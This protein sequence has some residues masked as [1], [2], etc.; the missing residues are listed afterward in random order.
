MAIK[1][2]VIGLDKIGT[3]FGLALKQ[4]ADEIIRLGHDRNSDNHKKALE[5][6]AFDETPANIK[7]A[8]EDADIVVLSIPTDEL[9]ETIKV[10]APILKPGAVLIDTSPLKV[11]ISQWIEELL[12]EDRYFITLQPTINPIYL[13][14]LEHEIEYA[15]DD[16]FKGAQMVIATSKATDT[17]ALKLAADLSRYLGAKPYF[18]DPYEIDGL[19]AGSDILPRLTGAAFVHAVMDQ[20]GW[21]EGQKIANTAFFHLANFSRHQLEREN[22]GLTAIQNKENSIRTI[23]NMMLALQEIRTLI[24]LEDEKAIHEWI[25]EAVDLQDQWIVSR[26]KANWD[27]IE[28]YSELPSSSDFLLRLLGIRKKSRKS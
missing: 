3:S 6:N 22:F 5:L 16:L 15:H 9:Y 14:E 23:N 4:H 21:Q 13:H 28:D 10:I 7:N 17:D 18:A 26:H 27:Q 11:K 24:E 12:P 25:N 19:I 8:V 1:L 20:P 2:A